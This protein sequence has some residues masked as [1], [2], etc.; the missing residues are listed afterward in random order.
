MKRIT[1]LAFLFIS[2]FAFGQQ[3]GYEIKVTFKPFKNQYIYLGH[4]EGKQLPII[5]SVLVNEKSEGI[6][7]GSKNLGAGVYLIGYPNK[8]GFFEFLIGKNQYFSIKTDTTNLQD[9]SFKNSTDNDL[10]KNYQRFMSS[11][12]KKIDSARKLL[13]S[14]KTAKDSATI[15]NLITK[16]NKEIKDYRFDIIKKYPDATL[17]FLLKLLQEPEIPPA[18][19]HPGGKYDSVYAYKYFKSHFWDGI[20]FYDDRILRTPIFENKLDK[21]FEQLVYPQPDS[22]NKEIDWMLGYASIKPEIE[23]FLLLKF[24]NRY[25]TMKYMWEDAV[26]VHLYEKYFAQKTYPWLTEKGMKTIQDRAYNLMANILGNAAP[27]IDLP[28]TSGKNI[29]LYNL[30]SPYTV[31]VIWDPTCGHCKEIVPKVDS[32]YENNWKA[33]GV[34]VFALAKET[35]G[36]KNDWLSFIRE[37]HLEKWANVYYSKAAEKARVD[38]GIP[39]YS[40]LYDVLSFPTLYLLD[41]D[42]R[43]IAKKLS[44]EQINDVLQEKIKNHQ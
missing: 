9:I 44:F 18:P 24:V 15:N 10:F 26:F 36:N 23:K 3:P 21:Y 43:I 40:Q 7:K 14:A 42:K 2:S 41:R 6:F 25:L 12:G 28:D 27:D 19:Q 8:Q 37:H 5:D 13:G 22:V 11:N 38:A 1:F 4:Y 33:V 31:I 30:S 29:T 20:N 34:K 39:G 35:D 32:M 17:S 16:K